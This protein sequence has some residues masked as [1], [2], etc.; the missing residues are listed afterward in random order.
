MATPSVKNPVIADM[1]NQMSNR[2][3]A[4][5]TN[6]CANPPIGCGGDATTFCN[7]LSAR[8]YTI[9]GLCQECQDKVFGL[10]DED[11]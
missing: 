5:Y 3:E 9:S 7:Q 11:E 8:E 10:D 4:I 6:K 1:L 2:S